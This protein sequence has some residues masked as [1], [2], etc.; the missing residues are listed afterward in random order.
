MKATYTEEAPAKINLDL[1]V[2]H[3]RADG[4]HEVSTFMTLTSLHDLLK[5]TVDESAD[6]IR[7]ITPGIFSGS[8]A[9]LMEEEPWQENLVYRAAK[10]YCDTYGINCGIEISLQK[11]IPAGAGLGGGSSDAAAVFRILQR[12]FEKASTL[13]LHRMAASLG[14]D[15]PFFLYEKPALCEGTGTIVTPFDTITLN[16]PTVII[17]DGIHV[18]TADAYKALRRENT[19]ERYNLTAKKNLITAGL[20]NRLLSSLT[21]LLH[22]DFEEPVFI[23]H[24]ELRSIRDTLLRK[25]AFLSRMS[26]SGSAVY[27]L[28]DT[29]ASAQ[30]AAEALKN[31]YRFVF[32]G[33]LV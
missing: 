8:F 31:S 15:I 23:P 16:I 28:F 3:R 18:S 19:P 21:D 25:G 32:Q 1:R 9:H 11:E 4:Y 7:G 27:G 13:E 2:G 33:S 12:H 22:N 10:I 5:L 14:A 20:E 29:I 17:H 26:G 6:E 24:P 30:E